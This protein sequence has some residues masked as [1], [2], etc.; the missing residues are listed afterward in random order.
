[1]RVFL[2]SILLVASASI[3][4]ATTQQYYHRVDAA[5]TAKARAW[6]DSHGRSDVTVRS[7]RGRITLGGALPGGADSAQLAEAVKLA[8][9]ALSVH[10]N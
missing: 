2:T 7:F 9:G 8:S 1:M 4:S 5:Q 3:A 6:L 10:A